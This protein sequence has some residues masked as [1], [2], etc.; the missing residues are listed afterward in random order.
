MIG[1]WVLLAALLVAGAV[2][3]AR[4]LRARSAW[5]PLVRDDQAMA[6][7][8]SRIAAAHGQP[9]MAAA[10]VRGDAIVAEAAVG[11]TAQGEG[12]PVHRDSRFHLGSTTKAFTSLL[13]ARLVREGRLG[14]DTTLSAA[15]PHLDVKEPYAAVTV[16]DLL[17][18]RAGLVPFQD[19]ASEDPHL[20]E[21]LWRRIPGAHADP[22]AQ[23]CEVARCAFGLP[24]LAP[25]GTRHTYSNVGWAIAGHVVESIA[26]ASY[27]ALLAREIFE[28]LGMTTA[29]VGGWPASDT[30]PHQPRGHYVENGALRPQPL[31]DGYRFPAWMNPSGGIHCSIGDFARFARETLLGLQGKGTLLDAAGYREIHR[32]QATVHL[33]EMYGPSLAAAR[34]LAPGGGGAD[35]LTLGFG[36]V[37]LPLPEGLLS[38]ADGSG[39]TFFARVLV[40]PPL[41]A[42]FVGITS[43]GSGAAALDAAIEA[44]T[45]LEWRS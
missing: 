38:A 39:G 16:G 6:R 28:P 9:A 26:G 5:V 35:T 15:L 43:A 23:R 42:A 29:R 7:T 8:L 17:L 27:E 40:F 45:G 20:V 19:T 24:P 11:V 18:S 4:F 22:P 14:Y 41:D 10:L 25:P 13:I 12:Q 21:E 37:V 30:E 3:G 1:S 31:H 33:A 32:V 2:L 34:G 36:W 44:V